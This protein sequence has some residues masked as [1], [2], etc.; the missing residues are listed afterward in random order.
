[1][2]I[3]VRPLREADL[4]L[5]DRIFRLAFGTFNGHPEPEKF[6]GDIDKIRSRWLADPE[7]AWGAAAGGRLVGS[8]FAARWGSVGYFGPLTV[9][10]DFWDQGV[11]QALLQPIMQLFERWGTRHNG[12]YTYSHSPKH[13]ALYQKYGFWPRFLTAI[14]ALQVRPGRPV[15]GVTRYSEAAAPSQAAL[16]AACRE[17]ADAVYPGLDLSRELRAVQAQGLGETLLVWE[18]E[19][20]A[21]FAVCHCGGGSEAG[22]GACLVKFGAVRPGPQAG[23]RFGRLLAAGEALAA[24]RGASELHAGVNTSRH[25]AYRQMLI[26]GF[27]PHTVGVA[28]HRPDAS[29][30]HNP[31]VYVI[32][33]WR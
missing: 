33:D 32:D 12:L 9:H 24:A 26:R 30:Y 11:G 23:Q 5:A 16:L 1:M 15:A 10:P 31:G 3:V 28:M 6:G 8:V 2:H 17:V 22:S 7:A 4:P 14:T 19:Q 21:G 13:L 20:L 27:R 25:E 18:G 29:A